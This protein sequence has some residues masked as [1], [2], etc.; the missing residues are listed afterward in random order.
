MTRSGR[1][2][3]I[4][5]ASASRSLSGFCQL[6]Q[7]IRPATIPAVAQAACRRRCRRPRPKVC[8]HLEKSGRL[9]ARSLQDPRTV[10]FALSTRCRPK[11]LLLDHKGLAQ[12]VDDLHAFAIE[13]G[14][15]YWQAMAT[16]YRGWVMVL[17]GRNAEGISLLESGIEGIKAGAELEKAGYLNER[18]RPYN[19][20]S[21]KL[22]LES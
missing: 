14:L 15:K 12:N 3:A 8:L 10:A 2:Y 16:S 17:E 4:E 6:R 22:M 21:I 13:H 9:I 19:P 7:N 5:A 20:N 11:Y 1:L 18:G